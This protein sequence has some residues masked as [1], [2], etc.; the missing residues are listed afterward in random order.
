M[1]QTEEPRD[2]FFRNFFRSLKKGE[3]LPD[4]V[5][6]NELRGMMGEESDDE[7]AD[8]DQLVEMLMEQ[9]HEIGSACKDNIVPFAVRWYTGEASPE[10]DDFDE[11]GEEEDSED[12]SDSE[13]ETPKG[14]KA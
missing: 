1:G 6:A 10:E 7:D 8:D 2:S 11:D 3:P 14:K 12:E 9:D 4:D 13:E 5:D